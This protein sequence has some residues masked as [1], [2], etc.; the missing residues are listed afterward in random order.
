MAAS[1]GNDSV[2]VEHMPIELGSLLGGKYRI[3]KLLGDGTFGRV[4]QCEY[5][6]EIFAVK[7]IM[8]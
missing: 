5:K 7:V 4:V 1:D 6:G 3:I 2:R 8:A